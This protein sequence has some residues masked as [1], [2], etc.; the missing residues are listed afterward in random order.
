VTHLTVH[1]WGR[2]EVGE[3]GFARHQADALLIAARRH[4][5]GG[6]DGTEILCDHHRFL[7]ARQ[8][9]GVIA[10]RDSSLEIL[11]KVDPLG[12]SEETVTVRARL[13]HMLDVAMGINLSSGEA[14]T[15]AHRADSLLEVFISLFAERLLAEVRR[16]LPRLYQTHEDDLRALRGRLN[17]V[18]QFTVHAV[19]PDRLAC[20][21]DALDA[22]VPLMKVMK[23]CVVLLARYAR[24]ADNQR[25]LAELR[26]LLADVRDVTRGAL[27]WRQIEIDRSNRRWRTLL[28]LSRLLLGGQWQQ[29]HAHARA[30]EGITLLFPMNDLFE[31]YITVQLRR[32][33]SETDLDVVAQG[34]FRYCLGQW[35]DGEPIVGNSHPTR[36]DILVKRGERVIAVLDTK[37]KHLAKGVSHADVYQM[38]AYARLYQCQHLILLYPSAHG[39]VA[40][41]VDS[42][43]IAQGLDRLDIATISLEQPASEIQANLSRLITNDCRIFA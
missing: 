43:G 14:T 11:P 16:G 41:E 27:P 39:A 5:L 31:R 9:V 40:A 42:R 22:D 38:I 2:V 19:R 28:D 25:K 34:G 35:A 20:R 36:P 33:L 15:M 4:A 21:F 10:S 23:A 6:I 26:F 32:A 13:I 18:R 17:V 1:E 37:W 12:A 24:S 3:G 29:T 8:M 30:P 7:R